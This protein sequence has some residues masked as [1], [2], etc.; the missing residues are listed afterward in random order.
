MSDKAIEVIA[1]FLADVDQDPVEWWRTPARGIL[2]ALKAAGIE[3]VELPDADGPLGRFGDTS[4][5]M[6]WHR[7]GPD[8][9]YATVGVTGTGEIVAAISCLRTPTDARWAAA[10]LLAAANAA[11][12]V[13][14]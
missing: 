13:E 7:D 10:A 12:A 1:G 4:H 8:G 3:V 14:A 2:T 11:E 5:G 9:G 6:A